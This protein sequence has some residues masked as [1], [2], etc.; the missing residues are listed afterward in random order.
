MDNFRRKYMGVLRVTILYKTRCRITDH[1]CYSSL[2]LAI[3]LVLLVT[4]CS[5]PFM[6]VT[7]RVSDSY[8]RYLTRHAWRLHLNLHTAILYS[9]QTARPDVAK[10]NL[11]LVGNNYIMYFVNPPITDFTDYLTAFRFLDQEL[12]SYRYSSCSSSCCCSSCWSD[13]F[14]KNPRL[15]HF[16]WDRDEIWQIVLLVNKHRL[17]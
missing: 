1:T 5:F 4:P 15:R 11:L 9:P 8:H 7:P 17:M 13:L 10:F 14:K 16:Q 3:N 12:I 6:A 2:T